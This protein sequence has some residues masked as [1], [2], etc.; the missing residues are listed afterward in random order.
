VVV[1]SALDAADFPDAGAHVR[2]PF[3]P[4]ELLEAIRRQG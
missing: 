3:A 1:V 2:K 4:Q